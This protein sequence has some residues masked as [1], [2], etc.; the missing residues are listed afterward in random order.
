MKRVELWTDKL[1]TAERL[2]STCHSAHTAGGCLISIV[3]NCLKK[4]AKPT[5]SSVSGLDPVHYLFALNCAGSADLLCVPCSSCPTLIYSGMF[6][7]GT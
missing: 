6:A 1:L 7:Q 3:I 2:T 5:E 4:Q